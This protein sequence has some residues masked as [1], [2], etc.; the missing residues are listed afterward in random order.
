MALEAL[1]ERRG[2]TAASE[3]GRGPL[4]TGSNRTLLCGDRGGDSLCGGS[5]GRVRWGGDFIVYTSGGFA[6]FFWQ[7]QVHSDGTWTSRT[8]ADSGL[9]WLHWT[10]WLRQAWAAV[11]PQPASKGPRARPPVPRLAGGPLLGQGPLAVEGV[12]PGGDGC[13]PWGGSWLSSISGQGPVSN[14]HAGPEGGVRPPVKAFLGWGPYSLSTTGPSCCLPGFEM[15]LPPHGL[16][17]PYLVLGPAW[18]GGSGPPRGSGALLPC[19][20]CR[21]ALA[22]S[23]PS[24]ARHAAPRGSPSAL[25]LVSVL[26]LQRAAPAAQPQTLEAGVQAGVSHLFQGWGEGAGRLTPQRRRWQR[27]GPGRQAHIRRFLLG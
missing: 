18:T 17:F 7:E 22:P 4:D 1:G 5:G 23:P 13:S 27:L 12:H 26:G 11:R 14:P 19:W 9:P 20:P 21:R 3:K 6:L 8:Q 25:W 16:L 15:W 24:Q 2:Q 10:G